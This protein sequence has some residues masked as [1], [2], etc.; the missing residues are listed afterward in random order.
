VKKARDDELIQFTV[1]VVGKDVRRNE[2]FA[3]SPTASVS[4]FQTSLFSALTPPLGSTNLDLWLLNSQ[5]SFFLQKINSSTSFNK[6]VLKKELLNNSDRFAK[7]IDTSNISLNSTI[8]NCLSTMSTT[9]SK[10]HYHL[11]VDFFRKKSTSNPIP[12]PISK[13]ISTS[14]ASAPATTKRPFGLCGLQNLG[15]TCYMNSALQCL[16]NTPQLTRWFL[17]SV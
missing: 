16:S 13:P 17:S 6:I 12:S 1:Y 11:A 2:K 8:I 4:E 10:G 7:K 9:T 15:N 5:N 14:T 3:I